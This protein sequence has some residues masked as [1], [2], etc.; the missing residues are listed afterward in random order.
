MGTRV[1]QRFEVAFTA[2]A[3]LLGGSVVIRSQARVPKIWD[4]AALAEWATPIA[5]LGLRPGHYT[6]AQYYK[7]P[8]DNLRTYPVNVPGKEP[9]GYWDWLQKQKPQ[10]LVDAST[11]RTKDDWIRAG[12]RAFRDLDKPPTRTGDPALIALA[13]N[14]ASFEGVRAQP[15]GSVLDVRWVITDTGVQLTATEC[16]SCHLQVLDD[17]T[18][19]IGGAA[20]RFASEAHMTPPGVPVTRLVATA[21]TQQFEGDPFRVAAWRAASTPWAPDARVEHLRDEAVKLGPV[22]AGIGGGVV[23]RTNGS[24][25]FGTKI[26]DLH[27]LHYSRYIDATGTHRLR[28]PED[29]ARYAALINGADS[30]DFGSHRILTPEQRRVHYRY[31]DEVLYAND[32]PMNLPSTSS[33]TDPAPRGRE[34]RRAPAP[35]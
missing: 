7:V 26:P 12:K 13:R 17:D 6:S 21:L 22:L 14:P 18:V 2:G 25:Y 31:A 29:V 3:I 11:I 16:S 8:A 20:G 15:D 28:G 30:M 32:R 23:F 19:L 34:T 24:P 4:D 5:A 35:A 9:A 1:K 27:I 10:P 33:G